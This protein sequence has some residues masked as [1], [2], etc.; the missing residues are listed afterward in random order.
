MPSVN[1]DFGRYLAPADPEVR[2]S[3]GEKVAGRE[4]GGSFGFS[5]A[6]RFDSNVA[7]GTGGRRE[8]LR[9][10][11]QGYSA[12]RLVSYMREKRRFQVV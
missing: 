7:S 6:A 8:P 9:P 2:N 11:T 12:T 1:E 10:E 4:D 3:G 5:A